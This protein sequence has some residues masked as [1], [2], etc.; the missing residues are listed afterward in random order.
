[1]TKT[2][3]DPKTDPRFQYPRIDVDEWRNRCHPNGA[4]IPYRYMHGYFEGT[5]N[6]PSSFLKRTAMRGG[7][8][9]T[10]PPSL[11]RMRKLPPLA[12]PA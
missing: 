6:F 2:I 1:M 12:A 7:S 11:D 8:T 3:Y 10:Y 9:S 4:C 5:S